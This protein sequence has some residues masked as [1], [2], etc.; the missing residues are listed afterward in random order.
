MS[1]GTAS[2]NPRKTVWVGD[3]CQKIDVSG[4]FVLLVGTTVG[5]LLLVGGSIYVLAS[6]GGDKLPSVL[7]SVAV[8]GMKE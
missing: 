5:L 4:P 2:S 1:R 8:P 7:G 3:K 6:V